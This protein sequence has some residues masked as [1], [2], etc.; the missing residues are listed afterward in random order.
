MNMVLARVIGWSGLDAPA[1][2]CSD[3][4]GAHSV[5]V[6]MVE[7]GLMHRVVNDFPIGPGVTRQI[8]GP[9]VVDRDFGGWEWV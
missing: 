2:C 8:I 5:R 3:K 7:T 4:L 9:E 1:W 6:A